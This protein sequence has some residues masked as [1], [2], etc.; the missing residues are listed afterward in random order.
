M[1]I[2]VKRYTKNNFYLWI[3]FR[4]GGTIY[5][6]KSKVCAFE[7]IKATLEEEFTL[8]LSTFEVLVVHLSGGK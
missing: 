6:V 2:K 7:F 8:N 4:P 3:F 1:D 5:W